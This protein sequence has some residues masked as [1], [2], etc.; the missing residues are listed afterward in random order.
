MDVWMHFMSVN[1]CGV[2]PWNDLAITT[3]ALLGHTPT[4]TTDDIAFSV[5]SNSRIVIKRDVRYLSET[6]HTICFS[7]F[8]YFNSRNQIFE[9]MRQFKASE[10][11][12][13]ELNC[14]EWCRVA[15]DWV[16]SRRF[17]FFGQFTVTVSKLIAIVKTWT[18]WRKS[19]TWLIGGL[20]FSWLFRKSDKCRRFFGS[21]N[22]VTLFR[23]VS[24]CHRF[25]IHFESKS[26][27]QYSI[28]R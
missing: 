16:A 8:C 6:W 5:S 22:G 17:L 18:L 13:I 2:R 14:M 7:P 25:R 24:Y 9:M 19:R 15:L 27:Q 10:L 12:W 1:M 11:N 4:P 20:N 3:L 23:S 26:I 28:I 21:K